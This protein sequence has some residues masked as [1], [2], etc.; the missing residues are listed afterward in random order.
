MPVAMEELGPCT[1]HISRGCIPGERERERGG[2]GERV[3]EGE[4]VRERGREGERERGKEGRG[5]E[6]ERG[7][8]IYM[9][10]EGIYIYIQGRRKHG[11]TGCWRTHNIFQA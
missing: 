1:R 9:R 2:E 8:D 10:V 7:R 5:S 3:G 4:G 11:C 6:I